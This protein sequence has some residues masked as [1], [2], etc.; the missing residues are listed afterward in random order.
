VA[1]QQAQGLLV[2]ALGLAVTSGALAALHGVAPA[3]SHAL[4]LGVLIGANVV[5]T[6]LRFGL[7]RRWVFR[8]AQK[9]ASPSAQR[10]VG[11]DESHLV[12]RLADEPLH[13]V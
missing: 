6:L 2:F 13:G 9:P 8:T 7:M 10:D 12:E 11:V 5:A 4:E 3:A 1:R